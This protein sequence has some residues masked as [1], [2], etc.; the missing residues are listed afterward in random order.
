LKS[1]Q[2]QSQNGKKSGLKVNDVKTYLCLFFKHDTTK[3]SINIGDAVVRSKTEI[4][5]LGIV[6]DSK[7]QWSNHVSTVINKASRVLNTI[8]LI[9]NTSTLRSF[10]NC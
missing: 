7:L 1:P 4:I 9:K 3:I 10:W 8:K 5:L 2:N 6:F